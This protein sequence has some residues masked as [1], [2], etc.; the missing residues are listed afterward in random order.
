MSHFTGNHTQE[1]SS[2]I[3]GYLRIL[4]DSCILYKVWF[5]MRFGIKVKK[6]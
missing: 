6:I 3:C 4:V 2:G 1:I 5:H